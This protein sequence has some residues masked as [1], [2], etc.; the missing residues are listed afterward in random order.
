MI[1]AIIFDMDGVIVD[2]ENI[3]RISFNECF[4]EL[5][6]YFEKGAWGNKYAGSSTENIIETIFKQRGIPLDNIKDLVAKRRTYY[7]KILK[8]N[9]IKTIPGFKMFFNEVKKSDLKYAVV[10]GSSREIIEVTLGKVGVLKDFKIYLGKEDY[11]KKKPEPDSF[12]K[13][14]KI[15]KVKPSECLVFEDAVVGVRAAKAA[16]MKCVA[17]TSTTLKENLKGADLFINN[18]T[19]LDLKNLIA[20]I[21]NGKSY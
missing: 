6:I 14:A 16:G 8:K 20:K 15:L 18:F 2:S 10:S 11:E 21:E 9:G 12:L 19:G 4:K 1:K 7:F 5:G 13:G 3:H 17:L